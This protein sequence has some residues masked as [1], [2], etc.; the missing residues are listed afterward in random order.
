MGGA[1][2]LTDSG[3]PRHRIDW[4]REMDEDELRKAGEGEPTIDGI[5]I[6]EFQT[7]EEQRE[8]LKRGPAFLRTAG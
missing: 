1:V 8:W 3:F 5:D 7:A 6:A 4:V 2:N